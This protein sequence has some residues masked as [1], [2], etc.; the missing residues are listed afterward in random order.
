M[1]EGLAGVSAGSFSGLTAANVAERPHSDTGMKLL[2]VVELLLGPRLGCWPRAMD[3]TPGCSLGKL[4][5]GGHS[6]SAA[7]FLRSS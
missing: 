1:C 4:E 3:R 2:L 5:F 6:R 7:F